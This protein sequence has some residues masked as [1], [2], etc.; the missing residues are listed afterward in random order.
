MDK[1]KNMGKWKAAVLTLALLAAAVGIALFP[2]KE[3]NNPAETQEYADVDKSEETPEY[4]GVDKSEEIPEDEEDLI[5]IH[6]NLIQ[7]LDYV[8]MREDIYCVDTG[9]T[10]IYITQEGEA[11]T[12]DSYTVA[13]PFHEGL[14]C[15]CKEGKYGFIDTEGGT[16][17]DFVYDRATPFVEGAA[18]FC[19][20]GS[21]GFMDRTGTPL[22]YLDCDSVSNFQEGLARIS[23]DGRYGY[24]NR[25][26]E[27]I[28]PPVYDYGSN[29]QDGYAQVRKDNKE[30]VIDRAGR[31]LVAPE[32]VEI[33]RRG[34]CFIGE[35]NGK[36]YIFD[37]QGKA[38]LEEPCDEVSGYDE[39]FLRYAD[40]G[41]HGFIHEGKAVFLDPAYSLGVIL[42]DRELV[43]AWQDGYQGVMSFQG[44]V[45]IPFCYNSITYDKGAEVFIVS[46]EEQD[47]GLI[48]ADDFSQPVKCIYRSIGPF[49]NGQAA[50][51]VEGK[52][53]IIDTQGNLILPLEYDEIHL[54]ENGAYWFKKDEAS[55]LFDAAGTLLNVGNYDSIMLRGSCY[56]TQMNY[57]HVGI[58]NVAGEVILEPVCYNA[59]HRY[60]YYEYK[61]GIMVLSRDDQDGAMLIRTQKEEP[62]EEE[63]TNPF[64]YNE[65]TPRIPQFWNLVKNGSIF[66]EDIYDWDVFDSE[67]NCARNSYMIYD[68]WHT[69]RPVL[70]IRSVPYVQTGPGHLSYSAFF[71][72][73]GEEAVCLLDGYECGGT[74]GG[75]EMCFWY[76]TEEERVLLGISGYAGGFGG[77]ASYGSV[78]DYED[79]EISL[80]V[81][82]ER[83]SEGV[84]SYN[85]EEYLENAELYY[86]SNDQ[87]CTRET[88]RNAG[89]ATGY[90]INGELTTIEHYREV[91]E[92]YH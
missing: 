28:I 72:W 4:A 67:W 9:D 45:K 11:L 75:D 54:L 91:R 61:A 24:I 44:E 89:V 55:Y 62:E 58:L 20:G 78:Y 31:E 12:P 16:V 10:W 22:F 42:H 88:I 33:D 86:D 13:Y 38:L 35:K 27:I 51:S 60:G 26:G 87:P 14:A 6:S 21:Y 68:Y 84:G 48:A 5:I 50:V 8:L 19:K 46:N 90:Y 18:Y 2:H 85:V 79:G 82:F 81:S 32:Y 23:V 52:Y 3:E 56:V 39:I 65:I 15:V 36:Y 47:K 1:L 69:G 73:K 29:F 92:R 43:I 41:K 63:W 66:T 70:H 30:G 80:R 77:V 64:R 53:G 49:V 83:I 34:D 57:T 37:S 17:I 59:S 40:T 25:E 71:S 76:D 7:N 74:A